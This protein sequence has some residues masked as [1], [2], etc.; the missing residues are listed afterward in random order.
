M[1]NFI[2]CAVESLIA[3]RHV[4]DHMRSYDLQTDDLNITHELL[5]YISSTKNVIFRARKIDR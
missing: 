4:H 1:E 5:D 3:Q 2:F